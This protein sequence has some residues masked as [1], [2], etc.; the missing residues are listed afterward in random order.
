MSNKSKTVSLSKG[1]NASQSSWYELLPENEGFRESLGL[2]DAEALRIGVLLPS[3]G[4]EL[5]EDGARDISGERLW[6]SRLPDFD[7]GDGM[8]MGSDI[9]KMV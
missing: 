5:S 6:G 9:S 8:F 1:G 4:D 3:R 2:L 7:F